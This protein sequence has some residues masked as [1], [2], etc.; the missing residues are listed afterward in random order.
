MRRLFVP[1]CICFMTWTGLPGSDSNLVPE[2][3]SGTAKTDKK[4]NARVTVEPGDAEPV[5]A[6][7]PRDDPA[8]AAI[9]TPAAP[10]ST[11]TAAPEIIPLPP[12]FRPVVV[13]SDR[14]ICD[15][16]TTAAESNNL[17]VHFFIS[18]LFQ[19]SRFNPAEVS[20]AGALGIAQFMPET[21][22]DMGLENPFDPA[23]AIP[24]SA[25][26]LR[27]L[28]A[29]FGNLGLAAAAY[30]AG[31]RRVQDWLA[32]LSGKTADKKTAKKTD[33]KPALPEET[34]GYVKTITGHPVETWTNASTA[35]PGQR[36]P[37]HAP[38]QE[39]AGLYAWSGPETIP[40]PQPSPLTHR[41]AAPSQ[42]A[43]KETKAVSEQLAA[44][45]HTIGKHRLDK[46]AQ[47]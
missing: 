38:C 18:L 30:N 43:S 36:L 37:R 32:K 8:A 16:L 21:A 20:T 6:K 34:Q 41:A 24:A 40:L 12:V 15:S 44:H 23:Q 1:A 25:R 11:E 27:N 47:Q 26:L 19:E 31:P 42:I 7:I 10:A 9:E 39:A 2:N 29:Q 5:V 35:M 13:R 33:P 45:R 22:A 4:I 46:V 14:E 3:F 28:V 17:P